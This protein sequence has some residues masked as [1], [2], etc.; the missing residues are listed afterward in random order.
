LCEGFVNASTEGN[1]VEELFGVV[2]LVFC[3]ERVVFFVC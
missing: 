2:S 3:R 1:I